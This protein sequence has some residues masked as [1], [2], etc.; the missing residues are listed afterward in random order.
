[1]K[2]K[3]ALKR[4]VKFKICSISIVFSTFISISCSNNKANLKT[5]YSQNLNELY[6]LYNEF[7]NEVN[8]YYLNDDNP[9]AFEINKIYQT[10]EFIKQNDAKLDLNLQQKTL[11]KI[12]FNIT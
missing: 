7:E 2:N 5:K 8:Q 6:K 9:H 11:V 12:Q 3:L 10:I 4:F 1:M